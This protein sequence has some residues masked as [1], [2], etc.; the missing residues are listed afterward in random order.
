MDIETTYFDPQAPRADGTRGKY[1]TDYSGHIG[2]N[3]E[4]PECEDPE[5]LFGDDM[6]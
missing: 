2:E 1:V 4:A 6:I 5:D 3:P